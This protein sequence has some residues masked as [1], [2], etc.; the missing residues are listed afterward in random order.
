MHDI[1]ILNHKGAVTNMHANLR[2]VL[3][4]ESKPDDS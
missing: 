2:E 1:Y 3:F 4:V